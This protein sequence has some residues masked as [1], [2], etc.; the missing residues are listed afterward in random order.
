AQSAPG[1]PPGTTFGIIP[2]PIENRIPM[3]ASGQIAFYAT[4]SNGWNGLWLGGPDGVSLRPRG[5]AQAPR[6][7]PGMHFTTFQVYDVNDSGE[8]LFRGYLAGPG[9]LSSNDSGVWVSGP[10][11]IRLVVRKG[12]QAPGRPQ[13]V[14]FESFYL[15]LINDAGHIL[16]TG[17]SGG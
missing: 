9:V 1:L 11:G 7:P 6:T 16:L 3:T 13:G 5:G 8:I 10:N 12:D 17:T 2:I 4:A 15:P 14:V